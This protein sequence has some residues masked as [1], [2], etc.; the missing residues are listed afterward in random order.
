MLVKVDLNHRHFLEFRAKCDWD[1]LSHRGTIADDLFELV[2]LNVTEVN[3]LAVSLRLHSHGKVKC[4][5]RVPSSE[6]VNFVSACAM[7]SSEL[8]DFVSI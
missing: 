1:T 8:V 7:S 6:L 5:E 2:D 4:E 3:A